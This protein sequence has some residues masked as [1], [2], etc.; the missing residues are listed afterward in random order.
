M[1]NKDLV[2]QE[3]LDNELALA[4]MVE[5]GQEEHLSQDELEIPFLRVAQ[6]GSPQVDDDKAEFIEGLKAGYFFNTATSEFYG[7]EV[8]L[9]VHGYYRNF[10]IWK[11]AKGQGE[12]CGTMTP[13]EFTEYDKLNKLERD[14][15]DM[16]E[17][18][19]GIEMR[20]T[21]TRN[22][23]VSLADKPEEG[24]LLYPMS[25]TGIKPA[26]K[27]NTLNRT[28]RIQGKP[29]KRYAT[30]WNLKTAGF[31]KDK[32]SWKQVSNITA[33]GWASKELIEFGK[34]FEGFASEV[35]QNSDKVKYD[36]EHESSDES[37]Y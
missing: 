2:V 10:T 21:D 9:Q 37:D 3:E 4:M 12:Y 28:R 31:E 13:E 17:F 7:D 33:V 15:G 19:D 25:S 6:K 16:V 8:Q 35:K 29:A 30:I 23:L 32:Y 18:I 27:W 22:F 14:G 11:G 26:K 20:Y 1:S 36:S 5:E 34:S 24:I